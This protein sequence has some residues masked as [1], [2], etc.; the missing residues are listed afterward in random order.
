MKTQS[1][2][3]SS[4]MQMWWFPPENK[5]EYEP[6]E[7]TLGVQDT[8]F[9]LR[10]CVDFERQ[11]VYEH[12]HFLYMNRKKGRKPVIL[13]RIILLWY[14]AKS[15]VSTKILM[16]NFNRSSSFLLFPLWA[17]GNGEKNVMKHISF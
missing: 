13:A 3:T 15:W 16:S 10:E 6:K 5:S 4:K 2:Q 12:I 14:H 1:K 17:P 8:A 7:Q 9:Y 11:K